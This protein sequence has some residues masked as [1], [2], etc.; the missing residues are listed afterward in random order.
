MH[1]S[2]SENIQ[3]LETKIGYKFKKKSLIKE[4]LTHKS[5]TKERAE[6]PNFFNERLEFL[7]DAVLELAVTE[8]LFSRFPNKEEGELTMY[9]ASLVNTKALRATRALQLH[10]SVFLIQKTRL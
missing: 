2:S 10:L 9:R 5:F 7:G 6:N 3:L 1:V 8:E 4:A